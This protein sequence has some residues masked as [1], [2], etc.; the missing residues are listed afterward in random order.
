MNERGEVR[1]KMRENGET[2][3]LTKEII[4]IYADENI[5]QTEDGSFTMPVS[6]SCGIVQ[7]YI[8]P[9]EEARMIAVASCTPI[10]IPDERTAISFEFV[11]YVNS[12][13]GMT[14]YVVN[15]PHNTLACESS[16]HLVDEIDEGKLNYYISLSAMG[17]GW[18]LPAFITLMH[19]DMTIE[20][21]VDKVGFSAV[22]C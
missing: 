9:N 6:M 15:P 1:P 17:I 16:W 5:E 10:D 8:S 18:V 20:E 22:G 4:R 13:M 19:T 7:T 2:M 11:N 3:K 12:M 14:K 21:V